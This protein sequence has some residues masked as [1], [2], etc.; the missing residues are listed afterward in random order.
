MDVCLWPAALPFIGNVNQPFQTAQVD[1]DLRYQA[2]ARLSNYISPVEAMES[3]EQHPSL[4][5]SPRSPIDPV[6]FRT[7][8]RR[9][10]IPHQLNS[11]GQSSWNDL[12]APVPN[13]VD[14]SAFLAFPSIQVLLI[15]PAGSGPAATFPVALAPTRNVAAKP[16]IACTVFS[17]LC[18]CRATPTWSILRG[19]DTC[20]T[21]TRSI[22][23][24]HRAPSA[25]GNQARL[26]TRAPPDTQDIQALRPEPAV[27]L[28]EGP[29]ALSRVLSC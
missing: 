4:A 13:A 27:T 2:A 28:P 8:R 7:A 14:G 12:A 17:V 11:S 29:L 25:P 22:V 21:E 3:V 9:A 24:V 10:H 23:V 5:H 6:R 20:V 19:T 26:D 16:N 18:R 15:Q 1:K